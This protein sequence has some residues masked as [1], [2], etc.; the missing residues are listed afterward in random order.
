MG[1]ITENF[2]SLSDVLKTDYAAHQLPGREILSTRLLHS[3][4]PASFRH[5]KGQLIDV[6][7]RV[8]GPFDIVACADAFPTLGDGIAHQFLADGVALCIQVRNWKE[9]DLTQFASIADQL[10]QL[11]R[12]K[13]APIFCAVV[14]FDNMSANQVSE[15]MKSTAGKSIDGILSVGEHVIIRNT[16]G[17][18]GNAQKIP[19]VTA[20]GSGESLKSFA[21]WVVQ[22]AQTYLGQPYSL[23]DYQHL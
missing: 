21:F 10:K 4:L 15:F 13:K 14:G 20:Q 18:Y 3:L 12:K 2:S 7:D 6:K 16:Q 5:A 17:W 23:S 8:A 1:S 11:E 19:F 9:E 22:I